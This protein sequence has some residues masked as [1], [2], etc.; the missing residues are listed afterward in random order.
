MRENS[1][2][3]GGNNEVANID[4][5]SSSSG[6]ATPTEQHATPSLPR[7]Q[8]PLENS[9]PPAPSQPP[10]SSTE[11]EEERLQ[12]QERRRQQ[13]MRET[14]LRLYHELH[15]DEVIVYLLNDCYL[16][17]PAPCKVVTANKIAG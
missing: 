14:E 15:D 16:R 3:G 2:L 7:H 6:T 13:E 11:T 17:L 8:Q 5:S 9:Q 1:T 4:S 12:R 10:E